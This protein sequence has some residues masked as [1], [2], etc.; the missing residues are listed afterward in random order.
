MPL[1]VAERWANALVAAAGSAACK[2]SRQC[3]WRECVALC[4]STRR[5]QTWR[6]RTL[7]IRGRRWRIAHTGR[8]VGA[9]PKSKD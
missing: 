8:T 9:L 4:V 6:S 7:G 3:F 2:E 1:R 5:C